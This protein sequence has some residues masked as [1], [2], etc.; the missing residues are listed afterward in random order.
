MRTG[1]RRA[2][3]FLAVVLILWGTIPGAEGRASEAAAIPYPE[4]TGEGYLPKDSAEKEFVY[5]DYKAGLWAY[6]SRDLHIVI[7]RFKGKVEGRSTVW[8]VSD[9]RA[10]DGMLLRSF[11]ESA[12]KPGSRKT[13]PEYIAQKNRVVYAQ[14]GDLWTWRVEEK[15]YPG[16]IIRDGQIIRD[17]TYKKP[18]DAQPPLDELSLY[19]D[20]RLEVR[21][22]GELTGEEYLE[23]GA[24]DVFSF[25]PVLISDGQIDPRLG[26]F[27]TSAQPRSAIG[28][29]EPGHYVGV[30][31]EGRTKRSYGTSLKFV[32]GVLAER[33]CALAFNLDGGQTS[34]MVFMGKLVMQEPTYNGYT[35]TRAQPDIIGIGTSENVKE[36]RK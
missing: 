13:R 6:V 16:I 30:M 35:N 22:P 34:A 27:F 5:E 29:I 14:N 12:D 31:V 1:W 11:Q 28:M 4:L 19:R 9:I 3:A 18:V 25:G 33:G 8:F 24:Y 21:R 36:F 26:K 7:E 32:A 23:R 15:R 10:R 2:L 20:G 17:K